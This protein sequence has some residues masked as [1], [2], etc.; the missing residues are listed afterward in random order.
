MTLSL[1]DAITLHMYELSEAEISHAKEDLNTLFVIA[2]KKNLHLDFRL[3][4]NASGYLRPQ[5]NEL[6]EH[7]EQIS[8]L[9]SDNATPITAR[10]EIDIMGLSYSSDC[11]LPW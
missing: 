6:R 1:D 3:I 2:L 11:P 4:E 5:V 9:T 10:L 8:H 7:I